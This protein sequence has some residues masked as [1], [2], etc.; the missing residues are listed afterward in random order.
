MWI[1]LYGSL[2][3]PHIC[4]IVDAKRIEVHC[5]GVD[6]YND[7]GTFFTVYIRQDVKLK[8]EIK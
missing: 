8:G 1:D 4:G 3:M 2:N 5:Y 6:I 7:S